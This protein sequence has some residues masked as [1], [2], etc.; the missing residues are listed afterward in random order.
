[1]WQKLPNDDYEKK[2]LQRSDN[3]GKTHTCKKH[4][5]EVLA[6]MQKD[7][8]RSCE[9]LQCLWKTYGYTNE[10]C[11]ISFNFRERKFIHTVWL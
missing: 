2:K 11:F 1:M 3:L 8:K 4:I 7:E 6:S 9:L 5:S 10:L